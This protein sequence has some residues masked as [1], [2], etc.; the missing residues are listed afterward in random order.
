MVK[1]NESAGR[2]VRY[3]LHTTVGVPSGVDYSV[4]QAIS[5]LSGTT[6]K[7]SGEAGSTQTFYLCISHNR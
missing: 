4:V 2:G 6:E 7:R 1:Q 3:G 5:D